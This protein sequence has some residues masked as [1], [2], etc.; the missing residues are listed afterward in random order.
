VAVQAN[1]Q[2]RRRA[3][4]VIAEQVQLRS[5]EI[6]VVWARAQ[7]ALVSCNTRHSIRMMLNP[8]PLPCVHIGKPTA[9]TQNPTAKASNRFQK[10]HPQVRAAPAPRV[11][12]QHIELKV[13]QHQLRV[14][15]NPMA[16]NCNACTFTNDGGSCCEM[17]SGPASGRKSARSRNSSALLP[18]DLI[19]IVEKAERQA[20]RERER[21][22]APRAADKV[23]SARP[24][25]CH[26][27]GS[28]NAA[29]VLPR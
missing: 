10:P 25:L 7:S 20:A 9:H 19:E 6:L 27:C 22:P 17:C 2:Y 29:D 15:S 21:K 8:P 16:W 14:S 28:L 24:P 5:P 12:A 4:A 1:R 23:S 3:K 11:V 26:S 13:E 18:S